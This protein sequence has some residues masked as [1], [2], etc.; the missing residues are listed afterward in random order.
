[1][2]IAKQILVDIVTTQD[3][4]IFFQYHYIITVELIK[5]E[6]RAKYDKQWNKLSY[7]IY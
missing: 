7:I 1:M 6:T 3:N 4:N 2:L 5:L